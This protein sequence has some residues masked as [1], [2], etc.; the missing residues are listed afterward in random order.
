MTAKDDVQ[1]ALDGE[2]AALPTI[3]FEAI[4]KARIEKQFRE[5]ME[6][7]LEEIAPEPIIVSFMEINE[8]PVLKPNGEPLIIGG[9]PSIAFN[10]WQRTARIDSTVP[11][12]LLAKVTSM[13]SQMA[14]LTK[15]TLTEAEKIIEMQRIYTECILLVWQKTEPDMGYERLAKGLTFRQK[16]GLFARFF[17][18]VTDL[19]I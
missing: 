18:K 11:V 2:S 9:K 1:R 14:L 17:A 8:E 7:D 5:D 10:K 12:E 19:G 4:K 15:D 13:R 3:D 6:M 16:R